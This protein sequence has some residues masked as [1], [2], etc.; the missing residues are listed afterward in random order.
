MAF[1]YRTRSLDDYSID[2]GDRV[3]I[4][5]PDGRIVQG[6]VS[7]RGAAGGYIEVEGDDGQDYSGNTSDPGICKL[8][9]D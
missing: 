4:T 7:G 6:T 2:I 8:F 1:S 9:R 5:V 3:E